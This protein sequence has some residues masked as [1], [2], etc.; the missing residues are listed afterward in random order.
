MISQRKEAAFNERRSV[1]A[2]FGVRIMGR[3][4]SDDVARQRPPTA[5]ERSA[6][7]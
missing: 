1:V 4:L 7:P 6:V 3:W 2:V 5:M